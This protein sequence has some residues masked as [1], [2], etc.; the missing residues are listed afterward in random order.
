M[1]LLFHSVLYGRIIETTSNAIVELSPG[2]YF[3]V[4]YQ[5]YQNGKKIDDGDRY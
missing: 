1:R 5:M 4:S 3:D 2:T